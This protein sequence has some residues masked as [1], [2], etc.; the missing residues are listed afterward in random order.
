MKI[1]FLEFDD[2]TRKRFWRKVN[3]GTGNKCW[4]WDA[5]KTGWGYGSF[6]YRGKIF[7]SHRISWSL[8]FE[9]DIPC[10]KIILHTCDNPGCVNPNH[11]RVGTHK[12][13]V[14]DRV[15]KGRSAVGERNG[16]SKCTE[17][18]IVLIREMYESGEYN[19]SQISRLFSIDDRTTRKILNREIWTHI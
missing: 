9:E 2:E 1:S 8:Y 3:V 12:D 16:R 14:K 19:K 15:A 6:R 13:N 5:G 10:E 7:P 4:E 11:L 17:S 18:D